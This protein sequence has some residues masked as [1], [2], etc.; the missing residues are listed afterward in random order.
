[1]SNQLVAGYSQKIDATIAL[2]FSSSQWVP[3]L[4]HLHKGHLL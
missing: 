3:Q 1:M 4:C 2:F